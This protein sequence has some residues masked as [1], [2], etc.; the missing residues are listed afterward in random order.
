LTKIYVVLYKNISSLDWTLEIDTKYSLTR[1]LGIE[2][3]HKNDK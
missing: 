1:P 3:T 2:N